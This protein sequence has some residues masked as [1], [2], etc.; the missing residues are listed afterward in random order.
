MARHLIGCISAH[1]RGGG[2]PQSLFLLRAEARGARLL[3]GPRGAGVG[4]AR[5][6]RPVPAID[7]AR[8]LRPRQRLPHR[9]DD[10][11]LDPAGDAP[12][13][14]RTRSPHR[15][16]VRSRRRH[17]LVPARLRFRV[18]HHAAPSRPGLRRG[19]AGR[20]PVRLLARNEPLE[21]L[22]RVCGDR[23]CRCALVR[24]RRHPLLRPACHR[25]PCGGEALLPVVNSPRMGVCAYRGSIGARRAG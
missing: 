16:G 11:F 23:R 9:S 12:A 22:C 3:D 8:V 14:R 4:P 18:H 19:A 13:R 6:P 5:G 21:W 7:V 17:H 10:V 15:P 20:R 25:P 2:P 24:R 1:D